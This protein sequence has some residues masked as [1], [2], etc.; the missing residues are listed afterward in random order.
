MFAYREE[1]LC[2]LRIMAT[3]LNESPKGCVEKIVDVA[4]Y[5]SPAQVV[6]EVLYTRV[7]DG[8]PVEAGKGWRQR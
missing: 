7:A 2:L 1:L 5:L 4:V 8:A 3:Q 6:S